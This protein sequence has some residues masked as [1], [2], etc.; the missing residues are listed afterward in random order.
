MS[1]HTAA[2][3]AAIATSFVVAASAHAAEPPLQMSYPTDASLTCEGLVAEMA[4]MDEIM[5]VST[6]AIGQAEGQAAAVNTAASVGINA[7]LYSGALGRVP[8]LGMFGNAAAAA[9]K[10]N[11]EAKAKQQQEIIQTAQGRRTLMA[12]IYQGKNCAAAPATAAVTPA[13]APAA[14]PA[15]P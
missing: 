11:A 9:A 5:G 13:V 12:G 14:A 10:R 6:S 2:V 7:A 3:V 4:R 8:G 15:A 1:K